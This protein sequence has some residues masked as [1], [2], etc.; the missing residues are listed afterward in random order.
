MDA[1]NS[2]NPPNPKSNLDADALLNELS[3]HVSS[4]LEEKK[5]LVQERDA[6]R[7]KVEELEHEKKV[8]GSLSAT[9]RI[10]LKQQIDKMINRIDHYL[11]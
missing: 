2:P 3:E 9:N 1:H 8:S 4:L 6:L 10:V 5:K 7:S 11:E